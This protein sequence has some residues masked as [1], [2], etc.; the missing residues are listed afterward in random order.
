MGILPFR[1][2][3]VGEEVLL[4]Q[5]LVEFLQHLARVDQGFEPGALDEMLFVALPADAVNE[6]IIQGSVFIG[7]LQVQRAGFDPTLNVQEEQRLIEGNTEFA[8]LLDCCP[9]LRI[10]EAGRRRFIDRAV[11]LFEVLNGVY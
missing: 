11:F 4:G 2:V 6:V 1:D 5:G 8:L 9:L 10:E 7:M 3:L